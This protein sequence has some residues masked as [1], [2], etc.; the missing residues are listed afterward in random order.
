LF[1]CER[2]VE[3]DDLVCSEGIEGGGNT[4]KSVQRREGEKMAE[5]VVGGK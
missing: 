4:D 5:E 2:F 1:C 3:R